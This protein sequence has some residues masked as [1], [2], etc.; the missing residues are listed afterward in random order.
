M[1][2]LKNDPENKTTLVYKT[3]KRKIYMV[4]KRKELQNALQKNI[5]RF[6]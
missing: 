5:Q 2:L 4:P 3:G 1:R 6:K